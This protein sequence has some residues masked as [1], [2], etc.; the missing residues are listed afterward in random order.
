MKNP[1]QFSV[2]LMGLITACLICTVSTPTLADF[3]FVDS[4]LSLEVNI[5]E[6]N[7]EA[8]TQTFT[9]NGQFWNLA[10]TVTQSVGNFRSDAGNNLSVE[11]MSANGTIQH[12]FIPPDV[13]EPGEDVPGPIQQFF[14]GSVNQD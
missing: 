3:T 9:I 10:L 8:G 11:S 7:F 13:Q 5:H 1:C 6:N 4:P 12:I 14:F 2:C